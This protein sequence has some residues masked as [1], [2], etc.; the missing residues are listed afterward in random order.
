[1]PSE[2]LEKSSKIV[3]KKFK[4]D[5]DIPQNNSQQELVRD[6]EE[7]GEE[8]E[9]SLRDLKFREWVAVFVLCFVNLINYMDRFTIAVPG[10]FEQFEV[11]CWKI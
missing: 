3:M 8:N 10:S 7:A 4:M 1:M 11:E 2:K 5:A 6:A 9:R